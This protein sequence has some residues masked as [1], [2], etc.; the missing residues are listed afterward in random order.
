MPHQRTLGI[1]KP[2]AV[3]EGHV[4]SIIKAIELN[5]MRLHNIAMHWLTDFRAREF[6]IEHAGKPFY[7]DLVEFTRSGPCVAM[8]IGG[9]DAVMKYRKLMGP[10]NPAEAS[11]STLRGSFGMGMPNNAVHGSA[12]IEDA[13]RE[14]IFF[15][16]TYQ[17]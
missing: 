9:E 5:G 17:P 4:G 3:A 16:N 7:E 10:T 2:D 13:R 6:Y 8:V 15:F 1:I 11:L 14:T 12:S